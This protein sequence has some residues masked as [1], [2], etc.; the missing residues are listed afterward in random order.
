MK[1]PDDEEIEAL[2][3]R[4]APA[5]PPEALMARLRSAAPHPR[6]RILRPRFWVPAAA[7]AAVL[8]VLSLRDRSPHPAGSDPGTAGIGPAP[9][10][11]ERIPV[12][13]RQHL[14]EVADLGIARGPREEPVRLIRT[15][16]LDEIY[17]LTAPG[18]APEKEARLREEVLPVALSTY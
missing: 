11:V 7:A 15:T 5:P 16:W 3:A 17:Y 18:Q 13:S 4:L 1:T 9:E 8:G 14:M 6:R 2:L 10:A 12:G